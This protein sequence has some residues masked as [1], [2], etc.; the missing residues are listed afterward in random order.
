MGLGLAPAILP[1]SSL[2]NAG[3]QLLRRSALSRLLRKALRLF[4]INLSV[5][6]DHSIFHEIFPKGSLFLA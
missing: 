3:E 2:V 6:N 5:K 4:A 1:I